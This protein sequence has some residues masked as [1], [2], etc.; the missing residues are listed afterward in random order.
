MVSF[1]LLAVLIKKHSS[2][3]HNLLKMTKSDAANILLH[4]DY[5]EDKIH[6][7]Y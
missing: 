3:S 2:L 5:N 4:S 1:L 7:I 6:P